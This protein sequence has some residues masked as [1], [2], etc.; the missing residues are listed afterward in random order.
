MLDELL[1]RNFALIKE[2]RISPGR[3]LVV[4]SGETGTGKT[5]LLGALRLL[6]GAE[7]RGELVGPF[8]DE[9]VVEGRFIVNGAEV[10]AG[11]RIP[12]QG[13][14]RA[15]LDGSLASSPI[16]AERLGGVVEIVGQHDQL[17]LTRPSAIREL[18]DGHLDTK[19]RAALSRYGDA[20]QEL[21]RVAKAREELGGD[22]GALARELDLARFQADEIEKA[23][24][25]PGDDVSLERRAARL[26]HAESLLAHLAAAA[27]A[28]AAAGDSWGQVVEALRRASRLDPVLLDLASEAEHNAESLLELARSIRLAADGISP[29]PDELAEVEGRLTRLGE[30]RRKYGSSLG[31]VL[32]FGATARKRS[33]ELAALL[34]KAATIDDDLLRAQE[35]VAKAGTELMT[36]RGRAGRKLGARSLHHLRELGFDDPRLEVEVTD[37]PPES[38]GSDRLRL[39]FASDRRLAAG[40]VA[41]VASG[42]ELSRLILSLRLAG[43]EAAPAQ[44]EMV[45]AFDEIDTGV[46]GATALQLGQKLGALAADYQVLCVT[47]LPQVAAFADTHF[48]VERN[49]NTATVTELDG[50][51]RMAELSRMLAG[52]PDSAR[53]QEAAAELMALAR[54]NRN[55]M[56]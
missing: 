31:E 34:E 46:G 50:D 7:A 53:G 20:W 33:E 3:G 28:G 6:L 55:L 45:L 10:I 1:V 19:G 2:A 21:T 25:E 36:A 32:S 48:V 12:R 41:K 29:D 15:Y 49:D 44:G 35:E 17:S 22:R 11:R 23:R 43:L 9:A 4:V 27:E 30:M 38:S 39:L 51:R 42:G 18:V 56:Q 8:A 24:L 52:L 54:T 47:H 40:E 5:L 14:S 16:L 37:A 13:R 26:R